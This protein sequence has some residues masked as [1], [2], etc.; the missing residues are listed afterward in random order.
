MVG[1]FLGIPRPRNSQ[2][3]N[4]KLEELLTNQID[5]SFDELRIKDIREWRTCLCYGLPFLRTERC[6]V[7]ITVF[8]FLD[9]PTFASFVDKMN[10]RGCKYRTTYWE[11]GQSYKSLECSSDWGGRKQAVHIRVHENFT[12]P[13]LYRIWREDR[14]LY[15]EKNL[16]ERYKNKKRE[17]WNKYKFDMSKDWYLLENTGE[18][19]TKTDYLNSSSFRHVRRN[20]FAVPKEELE[21]IDIRDL[22]PSRSRSNKKIIN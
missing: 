17:L 7:D 16:A 5:A 13:L 4:K 8:K 18:E 2:H 3:S 19:K 10:E 9:I 15:D 21:D 22:P 20:P 11:K 14:K 1:E 6:I 12:T